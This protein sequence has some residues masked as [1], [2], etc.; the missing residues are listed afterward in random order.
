[1]RE[2]TREVAVETCERSR[3]DLV[4][5]IPSLERTSSDL[6]VADEAGKDGRTKG[7]TDWTSPKTE[8]QL[9]ARQRRQR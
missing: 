3:S 8:E 6:P 2:L 5:E 9:E 7:R 1:M 4:E